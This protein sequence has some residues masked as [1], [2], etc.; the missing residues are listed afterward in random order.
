MMGRSPNATYWV[1]VEIG[2]PVPEKILFTIY[3]RDGHLG[4]VTQIPQTNFRSPF[5]KRV[6]IKFGFDLPSGF[7]EEDV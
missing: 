4:H 1:L 5:S 2:P 6:Q 3:G 7:V